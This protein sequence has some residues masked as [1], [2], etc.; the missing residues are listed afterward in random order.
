MKLSPQILS[1]ILLLIIGHAAFAAW[2]WDSSGLTASGTNI[3]IL[4][5]GTSGSFTLTPL[6]TS[7]T[8]ANSGTGITAST[9]TPVTFEWESDQQITIRLVTNFMNQIDAS[10]EI[11]MDPDGNGTEA[12][13]ISFDTIYSQV[14]TNRGVNGGGL[15]VAVNYLGTNLSI[16]SALFDGNRDQINVTSDFA[17]LIAWRTLDNSPGVP[18]NFNVDGTGSYSWNSHNAGFATITNGGLS[19]TTFPYGAI[20]LTDTISR[21]NLT[22]TNNGGDSS[23]AFRFSFDG[24][25]NGVMA[26]PEP[27]SFLFVALAGLATIATRRRR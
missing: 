22:I 9:P 11:L 27:S 19:A 14:I 20:D 1:P 2:T 12:S 18:D 13:L 4:D 23:T 24:G 21:Q 10:F 5:E 15:G 16:E 6:S 17:S 25:L 26:V 3:Y 8:A 7:Y